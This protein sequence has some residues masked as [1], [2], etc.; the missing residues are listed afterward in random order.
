MKYEHYLKKFIIYSTFCMI[1][2]LFFSC[3]SPIEQELRGNPL[4]ITNYLTKAKS[5]LLFVIFLLDSEKNNWFNMYSRLYYFYFTLARIK[6]FFHHNKTKMGTHE[7][8]WNLSKKGP[9]KIF[10]EEFK[11]IRNE[12]D[13]YIIDNYDLFIKDTNEKILNKHKKVFTEQIDTIKMYCQKR[14][15]D[16]NNENNNKLL[17]DILKDY[18]TF[19]DLLKKKK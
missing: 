17:S 12:C 6:Y 7:D 4:I 5:L 1:L 3:A 8:V 9:K 2:L 11:N 19:L 18:D 13:Y 16:F 15:E 10:G 14:G